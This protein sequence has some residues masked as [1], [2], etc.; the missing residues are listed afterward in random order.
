MNNHSFKPSTDTKVMFE[1]WRWNRGI[2][3]IYQW[4]GRFGN[5]VQQISNAIYFCKENELNFHCP[6]EIIGADGRYHEHPQ[7]KSFDVIFGEKYCNRAL[8]FFHIPS[9]LG[10]GRPDYE[11]GNIENLNKFRRDICHKYIYNNL[12]IDFNN[13][14][15]LPEDVVVMHIRGGDIFSRKNY[16]CPVVSNYLQNPLSYYT[17]IS[18]NYNRVI[19][20]TEDYNNPIINELQNNSKF[21]I[22]ILSIEKTIETML[23]SQSIVTSGVSSFGVACSL[24]SKNVKKV[25]ASN[26]FV[27]EILNYRD[28]IQ[29]DIEVELIDIDVD[30]YIK[31]NNWLNTDEQRKIMIEYVL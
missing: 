13:V 22:N 17:K 28:L 15:T 18:E 24:L 10:N 2:G 1:L 3:S 31:W 20:L 27:D 8:Y 9:K 12:K 5:N 7:I 16:Y 29:T 26:L 30:R 21:E 23:S 14:K 19:V 6:G 4:C 11:V 25:Y